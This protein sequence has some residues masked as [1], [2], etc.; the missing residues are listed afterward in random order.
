MNIL[1]P[2]NKIVVITTK[3]VLSLLQ[4]QIHL[5]NQLNVGIHDCTVT[6]LDSA[7]QTLQDLASLVDEIGMEKLGS[8]LGVDI[9]AFNYKF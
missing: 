9:S 3:I 4:K 7:A 2:F 5:M 8:D 1:V 6:D